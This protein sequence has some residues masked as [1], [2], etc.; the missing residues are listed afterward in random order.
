M[1]NSFATRLFYRYDS[2]RETSGGE[3]EVRRRYYDAHS[4][5]SPFR[6]SLAV[7]SFL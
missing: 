6:I 3:T 1:I 2:K 4:P 5:T 7:T